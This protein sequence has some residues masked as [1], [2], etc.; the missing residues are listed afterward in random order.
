MTISAS[1][2]RDQV[3]SVIQG[4]STFGAANVT[5][6][7]Y[8]VLDTTTTGY[9]VVVQW[10]SVDQTEETFDGAD[11]VSNYTQ[12]HHLVAEGYIKDYGILT[13]WVN[14][15]VTFADQM[16]STF[17]TNAS[18]PGT[19]DFAIVRRIEALP[20]LFV[21]GDAQFKRLDAH[22]ETTSYAED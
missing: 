21:R 14:H 15:Q 9:A 11:G 16:V 8:A 3:T 20:G 7:D 22:I 1:A 10:V 13:D 17:L 2:I 19:Y 5:T 6:G 12:T 4:I 18:A